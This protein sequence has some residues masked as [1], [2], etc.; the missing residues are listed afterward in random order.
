MLSR[1]AGSYFFLGELF[2]DLPLPLD[3]EP[4]THCGSCTRCIDICPTRAIVAP[5][6]LDARRCIAYL[7]IEHKGAIP[8]ELRP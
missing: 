8:E 2:T 4:A 7:T 3:A 5:R 6:R 1:D